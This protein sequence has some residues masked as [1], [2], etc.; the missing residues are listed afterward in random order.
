MPDYCWVHR[1]GR[2]AQEQRIIV[3]YSERDGVWYVYASSRDG[4]GWATPMLTGGGLKDP[5]QTMRLVER[6]QREIS[7]G[8]WVKES[9]DCGLLEE[10]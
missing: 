2:D 6:S 8:E 1:Y 5:N 7:R 3:A 4:E 10:R 9:G